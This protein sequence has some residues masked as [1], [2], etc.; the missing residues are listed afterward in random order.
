[1]PA[2]TRNSNST[3]RFRKL[4]IE[5]CEARQTMAADM[6]QPALE[7]TAQEQLMVELINRARANPTAEA[8][9]LGIDLNKDLP[10]QPISATPKQPLVPD[11]IL[12][13]IALAHT[14]D[15]LSNNFFDHA[16]S[17]KS[18]PFDR[19]RK[20]GYSTGAAENIAVYSYW[21][22]NSDSAVAQSHDMLF[23]SSGH[24]LN[25]MNDAMR[26]IGLG[27]RTGNYTFSSGTYPV[28]MTTENFGSPASEL[29]A[30][31]GVIYT[32]AVVDD[33]FYT[34][35]EGMG[36]IQVGAEDTVAGRFYQTTTNAAGGYTLELPQGTYVLRAFNQTTMQLAQL[37]TVVVG[38][39]NVKVDATPDKFKSVLIDHGGLLPPNEPVNPVAPLPSVTR[40]DCN[41]DG[42]VTALDA[43][44]VINALNQNSQN[45]DA[46]L[47]VNQDKSITALDALLIINHI[48][49]A[50]DEANASVKSSVTNVSS[51]TNTNTNSFGENTATPAPVDPQL[52]KL[53]QQAMDDIRK[54][55]NP[56]VSMEV[57]S[58]RSV[59]FRNTNLGL[60]S[61]VAGQAMTDGYQIIVRYGTYLFEYRATSNIPLRHVRTAS[62]QDYV[63]DKSLVMCPWAMSAP[64]IVA[65]QSALKDLTTNL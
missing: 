62:A 58:A 6:A 21:G 29:R 35:G 64:C 25:L 15:M 7:I 16:G 3:R 48:N 10:N 61:G 42:N 45:F 26:E 4:Q 19:A 9:R 30:I 20:A 60:K 40:V 31:T 8:T 43:L 56:D 53:S 47:D 13:Q 11:A 49:K 54:W 57:M 1:M 18:T 59:V 17:D 23:R 5:R 22:N 65:L 55:S 44:L 51:G 14:N 37:G 34:I 63:D 28:V 24:R 33:D 32:D 50:L 27:V 41:R 12:N 39:S 38:K 36:G 52:Q 46:S 2:N